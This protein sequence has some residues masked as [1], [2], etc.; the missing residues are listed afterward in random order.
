M[1]QAQL[2][3]CA[4]WRSSQRTRARDRG[5]GEAASASV[6]CSSD[7]TPPRS[8]SATS[9]ASFLLGAPQRAH[10]LGLGL[11]PRH[12][13]RP[14]RS[15][16]AS[17][18]A[19]SASAAGARAAPGS[20]EAQTP[21]DRASDRPAPASK[22]TA[23][24][25]PSS[26][27][28][29]RAPTPARSAGAPAARR[30]ARRRATRRPQA[31]GRARCRPGPGGSCAAGPAGARRCAAAH[32]PSWRSPT[33]R[34]AARARRA[35]R[36]RLSSR[37]ACR[38][39]A[40]RPR[41]R[42]TG[43]GPKPGRVRALSS[44]TKRSQRAA[45]GP[46]SGC[47]ARGRR[48]DL[49]ASSARCADAAPG[50]RRSPALGRSNAASR[51]ILDRVV[52]EV[53]ERLA[54][55]LA[56]SRAA[57]RSAGDSRRKRDARLLGHRLVELGHVAR[58]PR[59]RRSPPC[60]R[61]TL[62]ASARAIISSALKTRMRLS[63]SSIVPSSARDSRPGSRGRAQRLLRAVAQA[64]Q[65]RL[66]V[67][68]DV[69]GDL[70]A[71]PCISSS[72][73]SS[74]AL[75]LTASRSSSSFGAGD[76]Q[77]PGEVA[78]HDAA[79]LVA[80]M[81]SMRPSTRRRDEPAAEQRQQ[82]HERQRPAEGAADDVARSGRAPP[83]SR[84]TSRRKPPGSC[85]D[86]HQGAVGPRVARRSSL[87]SRRSRAAPESLSSSGGQRARCCRRCV[88]PAASVERDRARRQ[89]GSSAAR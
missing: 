2:A 27:R 39:A 17:R 46:R 79:R 72:I 19:G 59:P 49:D 78:R 14:R 89:A 75:R 23:G 62:P 52:D 66:E 1:R 87:V 31:S 58:R 22:V 33:A 74:M 40:A 81:A 61:A 63:A 11:A 12:E 44:R 68:G 57:G 67:V 50:R 21:E 28:R 36:A 86:A 56:V 18:S 80:V 15:S 20:A 5:V 83:R 9:S 48:R 26:R 85:D 53:G 60:P 24:G 10:H 32:E 45:R 30:G 73:R 3:G 47:R 8:A 37:R 42:A 70:A 65:R 82:H 41:R 13:P 25:S 38:H 16:P 51:G 29:Q 4:A 54:D 71:G 77:P 6:T 7:Q 76:R 64:G 84:P 55:Q 69:V 34:A 43:R 88:S 35:G